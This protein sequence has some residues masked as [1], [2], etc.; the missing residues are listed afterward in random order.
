MYLSGWLW[1]RKTS[2]KDKDIMGRVVSYHLTLSFNLGGWKLLLVI[3]KRAL[4]KNRDKNLNS[5]PS[6]R[7]QLYSDERASYHA[8]I[9]TRSK[10]M[11]RPLQDKHWYWNVSAPITMWGTNLI[12]TYK[13]SP[14]FFFL[15]L[16]H[17]HC[18]SALLSW[19]YHSP[20]KHTHTHA[21][22]YL[23]G[24]RSNMGGCN[25][26]SSIAVMPTAQISHSWL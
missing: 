1:Q 16:F 20:T 14:F 24:C 21:I 4:W 9:I 13:R 10:Q 3:K 15:T 5:R 25:S 23:M 2:E 8:V 22:L 12:L 11:C 17:I 19:H 18:R 7:V 6:S 26:A